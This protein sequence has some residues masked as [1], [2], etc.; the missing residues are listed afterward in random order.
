MAAK[1]T[2][3]TG[4]D[5]SDQTDTAA[6]PDDTTPSDSIDAIHD[7][8]ETVESDDVPEIGVEE[9]AQDQTDMSDSE[10]MSDIEDPKT[11]D[12]E[13][14]LSGDDT[15]ETAEGDAAEDHEIAET[16]LEEGEQD[17]ASAQDEVTETPPEAPERVVERV[18]EKRSVFIPAIFGGLFAGVVGYAVGASDQ[19]SSFLPESLQRK[20]GS[21]VSAE[22]V[23]A[24]RD[25]IAALE[26]RLADAPAAPDL[27]G[28]EA[29]IADGLAAQNDSLSAA[30]AELSERLD[31]L[32]AQLTELAQAP[33]EAAISDEAIAAYENELAAVQAALAQQR[34]E[35]EE[36]IAEAAQMEAEASESA[37]IARAQAA[38]TRLFAALDTSEAY[39]GEVT[40]LQ[41]LGVT[42]PDALVAAS[43]GLT[44]LGALQSDFPPLARAALSAAR[45]A[46][47]GSG[48]LGG[49]LQKQLGARSVTPREGDDPDAILSRAEAALTQGNIAQALT[50]LEALPD[51]AKA[52]LSDWMA[53]ADQR[54]AALSAADDLAQSLAGN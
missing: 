43:E 35:V 8:V 28:I 38:A 1:K 54:Q 31:A 50:E 15:V 45:D 9:E 2:T 30:D 10:D 44:S 4:Q 40:E 6:Q 36:M 21:E 3:S 48:G 5:T 12:A 11:D 53:A 37:R 7:H 22:E 42:V 33:V 27:S 17:S 47:A 20:T 49:F 16:P 29:Q 14:A 24:L 23:T 41:S 34:A 46:N 32:S 13:R 51:V 19:L 39:A 18:V 52:P 25:Q 26:A